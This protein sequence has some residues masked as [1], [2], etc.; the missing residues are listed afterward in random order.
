MDTEITYTVRKRFQDRGRIYNPG[1]TF[2]DLSNF[3]RPESMLRG[4]WLVPIEAVQEPATEIPKKRG[5]PK[6]VQDDSSVL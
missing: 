4:G 3:H 6:K 2:S 5:R 1:D